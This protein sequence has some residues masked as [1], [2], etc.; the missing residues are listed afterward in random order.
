MATQSKIGGYNDV[1]ALQRAVRHS[2]AMVEIGR[3]LVEESPPGLLP[4]LGKL[5]YFLADQRDALAEMEQIR[6]KRR[7]DV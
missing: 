1:A 3:R 7:N 4:L 2:R 5:G 6:V